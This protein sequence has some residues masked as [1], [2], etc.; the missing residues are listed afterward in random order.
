MSQN[1]F[2][3]TGKSI[4][5]KEIPTHKKK[6]NS[7]LVHRDVKIYRQITEKYDCLHMEQSS[8]Y[9]PT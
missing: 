9:A 8:L 5:D 4:L 7:N 1:L 6:E 2:V 3:S